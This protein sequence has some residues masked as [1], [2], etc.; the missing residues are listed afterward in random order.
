MLHTIYLY[1]ILQFLSC[2]G[3]FKVCVVLHE[4]LISMVMNQ[5]RSYSFF[6]HAQCKH[7]QCFH[8]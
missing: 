3:T 5:F 6:E 8:S 7:A 1:D 4:L 2:A